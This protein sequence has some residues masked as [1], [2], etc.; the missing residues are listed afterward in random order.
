MMPAVQSMPAN[1]GW[2]GGGMPGPGWGMPPTAPPE[3]K[4]R[5]SSNQ[6]IFIFNIIL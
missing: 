6:Y 2:G 5:T 3:V 1:W 4:V